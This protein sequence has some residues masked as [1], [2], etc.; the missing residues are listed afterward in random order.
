MSFGN[1]E[2]MP[3]IGGWIRPILG[4]DPYNREDVEIA[5]EKAYKALEILEDHFS[6][7]TY[8]V[9]D[10]TIADI[11]ATS[12]VARGMETVLDR[13]W[14][15]EHPNITRWFVS[16]INQPFYKAVSESKMCDEPMQYRGAVETECG[17]TV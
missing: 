8:L 7:N 5:K 11:F 2:L 12:L 16:I 17:G 14:R 6:T 10:M 3:A 15:H 9:G 4:R 13:E 1:S